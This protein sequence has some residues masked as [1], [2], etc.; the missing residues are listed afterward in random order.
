MTFQPCL[1]LTATAAA[2]TLH[3]DGL[4]LF[5]PAFALFVQPL[6]GILQFGSSGA[7][8]PPSPVRFSR[9]PPIRVTP[10]TLGDERVSPN[11]S[12]ARETDHVS[13]SFSGHGHD[14]RPS[15]AITVRETGTGDLPRTQ[16]IEFASPPTPHA[17]GRTGT[18][19]PSAGVASERER[20]R[21]R[22]KNFTMG[23]TGANPAPVESDGD[24]NSVNMGASSHGHG[25]VRGTSANSESLFSF[26]F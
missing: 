2:H 17:R 18:R 15:E 16:T 8:A 25:R 10:G 5:I 19:R 3:L 23:G 22:F 4:D 7:G 21:A 26:F 1:R 6:S 20:E 11:P 12:R 13:V 9:P 24:A 14:R